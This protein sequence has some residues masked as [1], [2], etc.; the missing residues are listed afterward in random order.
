MPPWA[1]EH[2]RFRSLV[3]SEGAGDFMADLQL[4]TPVAIARV[5]ACRQISP[6]TAARRR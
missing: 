3:R 1:E 6:S 4:D 2:S 5:G